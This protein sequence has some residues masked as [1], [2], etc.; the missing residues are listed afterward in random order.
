MGKWIESGFQ[1]WAGEKREI[2]DAKT[3]IFKASFPLRLGLR[4]TLSRQCNM[5]A[6][7]QNIRA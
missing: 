3:A 6:A 2:G 1:Q 7:S 5:H 4:A